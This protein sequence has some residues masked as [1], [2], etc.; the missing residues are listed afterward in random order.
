MDFKGETL[1]VLG[2]GDG[3]LGVEGGGDTFEEGEG[4]VAVHGFEAGDGGLGGLSL[5]GQVTL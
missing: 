4:G 1:K 2:E 3:E 5:F